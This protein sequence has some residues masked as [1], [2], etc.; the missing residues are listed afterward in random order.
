MG[1]P[2]ANGATAGNGGL[3]IVYGRD[4]GAVNYAGTSATASGDGQS[5]V[6]TKTNDTFNDNGHIDVSMRGGSGTDIFVLNN[7]DFARIDGGGNPNLSGDS[8]RAMADLD[9]TGVNFEKISGIEKLAY[10]ADGLTLTLTMENLFNLMKSSD[11]GT[12][13]IDGGSYSSA[14]V[15]TD[16]DGSD[17]YTAGTESDQVLNFLNEAAGGTTTASLDSSS[18]GYDTFKIGGYTLIIDQAITVDAQ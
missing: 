7:T 1:L 12:L 13:K 18:G 15:L 10:G 5:L 14:L 2:D 9:F 3:A 11:G 17:G 6:G 8:I 16:G 4:T